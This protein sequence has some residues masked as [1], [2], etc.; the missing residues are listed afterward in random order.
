MGLYSEVRAAYGVSRVLSLMCTVALATLRSVVFLSRARLSEILKT[1]IP[2]GVDGI[3]GVTHDSR[4]VEPGFAFVAIPG[5]RRDGMEFVP[6]ALWRGAAL[7]VAE[8]ELP[9]G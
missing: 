7:V 2:P 9:P 3:G 6:E 4:L 1:G 8:R 5:M